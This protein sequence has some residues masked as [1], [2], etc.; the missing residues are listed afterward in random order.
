MNFESTRSTISF[1][2]GK[3]G[4]GKTTFTKS[5]L[6]NNHPED[7]VITLSSFPEVT[8]F[9]DGH[10]PNYNL[11]IDTAE[12]FLS[13]PFAYCME[14]DK[15]M[16]GVVGFALVFDDVTEMN[17]RKQYKLDGVQSPFAALLRLVQMSNAK[18][19]RLSVIIVTQLLPN[20]PAY[21]RSEIDAVYF[22]RYSVSQAERKFYNHARPKQDLGKY[23][24]HDPDHFYWWGMKSNSFLLHRYVRK[25][26]G[27]GS[28]MFELA[29]TFDLEPQ[30]TPEPESSDVITITANIDLRIDLKKRKVIGIHLVD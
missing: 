5:L 2:V 7:T 21:I 25:P 17:H 8:E 20:I 16:D 28:S 3:R 13:D 23:A 1:V 12:K 26:D 27:H 19:R 30:E 4:S 24:P 22:S 15:R 18:H 6:S 10:T 11:E 29:G 9:A 14:L